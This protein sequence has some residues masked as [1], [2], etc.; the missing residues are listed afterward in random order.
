MNQI[1]QPEKLKGILSKKNSESKKD[2]K[3][4]R[5]VSWGNNLITDIE[6]KSERNIAK[7]NEI[8]EV[9]YSKEDISSIIN[10]T[11][12]KD[13]NIFFNLNQNNKNYN[14][15][16]LKN[17]NFPNNNFQNE[18]LAQN[19]FE[20]N[21]RITLLNPN[22]NNIYKDDN[23]QMNNEKI[24]KE[25]T[26]KKINVRV[27]KIVENKDNNKNEY[28]NNNFMN[29]LSN[30]LSEKLD[31]NDNSN[32][33]Y[34]N[35]YN[36][37]QIN[38]IRNLNIN[39]DN[40]INKRITLSGNLIDLSQIDN[41]KQIK[42]IEN[43]NINNKKISSNNR[44]SVPSSIN[45]L[46]FN[47]NNENQNFPF[48]QNAN[49]NQSLIINPLNQTNINESQF[50]NKKK[51]SINSSFV[52]E[53]PQN[54]N[55][56]RETIGSMNYLN[57]ILNKENIP[58]E[59]YENP[60]KKSQ[61]YSISSSFINN[62]TNL[63]DINFN[64]LSPISEKRYSVI[65][66]GVK[67]A[68]KFSL[69]NSM[70]TEIEN[71]ISNSEKESLTTDK[72]CSHNKINYFQ[73]KI[74]ESSNNLNSS[75]DIQVNPINFEIDNNQLIQDKEDEKIKQ[76]FQELN[77]L[78]ENKK[79]SN[80]K[81]MKQI[82]E[83]KE[84]I[85]LLENKEKESKKYI[86]MYEQEIIIYREKN[87]K[88][89]DYLQKMD[90]IKD[91]FGIKLLPYGN[92]EIND[93]W[94]PILNKNDN[95]NNIETFILQIVFRAQIKFT[96]SNNL[97]IDNNINEI[98]VYNINTKINK[99][100]EDSLEPLLE[101]D[102]KFYILIQTIYYNLINEVLF[103]NNKI[104]I[105][106]NEWKPTMKNI[107]KYSASYINCLNLLNSLFSISENI[108]FNYLKDKK[109]IRVKF[110]I[111]N[112]HGFYIKF[113]FEINLLNSFLGIE[114]IEAL[115][116]NGC[117]EEAKIPF[118]ENKIQDYKIRIKNYLKNPNKLLFHNFFVTLYDEVSEF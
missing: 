46:N 42:V 98:I 56:N 85:S 19:N 115:F 103:P 110:D 71:P 52:N 67:S 3:Q 5:K 8:E 66:S 12:R 95:I 59:S 13:N 35:E 48:N 58:I 9:S 26:T 50:I 70:L 39:N 54:S 93:T 55:N 75:S 7:L 96:V 41:N 91:L 65:K 53:E 63:N 4:Q 17:D 90:F 25:S 44:F 64:N 87:E 14:N 74:I 40:E 6:S 68:N 10:T 45:N 86:E 81:L 21:P 47:Q 107:M 83:I 79:N 99:K 94:N 101:K 15:N 49:L 109:S 73:D 51:F 92:F 117:L 89:K 113:L 77:I 43:N 38:N 22:L 69:P 105:H 118:Y 31:Y 34:N 2:S 11:N 36:N 1:N 30:F 76:Q 24:E 78:I 28:N 80:Q 82:N 33:N 100:N 84:K 88:L 57:M 108:D 102:N 20:V 62:N 18:F 116:E 27:M 104:I 111:L 72:K 114:L 97:F 23:E 16:N 106:Y 60:L 37:N 32:N 29:I 112:I 61:K